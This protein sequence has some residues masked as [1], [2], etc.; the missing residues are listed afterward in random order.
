MM[1]FAIMWDALRFSM[2][3]LNGEAENIPIFGKG[4]L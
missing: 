4:V 2:L 1:D 3:R